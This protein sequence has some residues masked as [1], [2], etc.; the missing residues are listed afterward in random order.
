MDK[1]TFNLNSIDINVGTRPVSVK[2][3]IEAFTEEQ[4]RKFTYFQDWLNVESMYH[5]SDGRFYV[6]RESA[7]N[8]TL[9]V[10]KDNQ[11]NNKQVDILT[12]GMAKSENLNVYLIKIFNPFTNSF[13]EVECL[14]FTNLFKLLK[15]KILIPAKI[16]M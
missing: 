9:E 3:S 16:Q 5:Y 1:V 8:W 7:K 11:G 2:H 14:L 6:D 12:P 4:K 15:V 13:D 10:C